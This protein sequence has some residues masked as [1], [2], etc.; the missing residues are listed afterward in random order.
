[1]SVF[2]AVLLVASGLSGGVSECPERLDTGHHISNVCTGYH[3]GASAYSATWSA[4]LNPKPAQQ[5]VMIF[6]YE[7]EWRMRI[8]GYRW[9]WGTSLVEHRRNDVAISDEDANSIIELMDDKTLERL[10]AQ[11]YF[12]SDTLICTDGAGYRLEK[13]KDSQRHFAA[14]HSCAGRTQ[15]NEIFGKFREIALKYDPEFEGFLAGMG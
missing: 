14:Q 6:R 4:S 5:Q 13:A 8:A 11:P 7:G 3:E 12:G 1:M 15:V 9:E 2:A 10:A